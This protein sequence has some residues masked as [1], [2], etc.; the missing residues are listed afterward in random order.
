MLITGDFIDT[1]TASRY[2]L[3]EC[4]VDAD[5]PND[6]NIALLGCIF[7]TSEMNIKICGRF[8]GKPHVHGCRPR[9]IG[10]S[11][12]WTAPARGPR[13]GRR[14][15]LGVGALFTPVSAF[16]QLRSYQNK[17]RS[18]ADTVA[19]FMILALDSRRRTKASSV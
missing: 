3:V 15:E 10:V 14:S 1:E 4:P 16:S 9:G 18:A 17:R 13:Q 8:A 2:G 11:L 12:S 19:I 5:D 6:A 7:A